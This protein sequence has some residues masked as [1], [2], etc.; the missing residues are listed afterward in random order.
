MGIWNCNI[1]DYICP[2]YRCYTSSCYN[3]LCENCFNIYRNNL[4][5]YIIN[6]D[7]QEVIPA[8]FWEYNLETD[9]YLCKECVKVKIEKRKELEF[10]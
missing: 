7:L 9:S 10:E 6:N 1:C 5:N 4:T 3:N 2:P 8:E